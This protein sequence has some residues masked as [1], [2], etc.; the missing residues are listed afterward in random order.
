MSEHHHH[1]EHASLQ[2][3][4]RAFKIAIVLNVLFIVIEVVAGWYAH[5]LS[6]VADAGHNVSDVLGLVLSWWALSLLDRPPKPNFTYG[7]G[8]STNLAALVNALLLLMAVGIMAMEAVDRFQHP[9]SVNEPIMMI[10]ALIG[11]GVNGVS[12][13]LLHADAD[14][15]LNQRGAFL[16]LLADALVSVGVVLAGVG[17]WFTGWT[18]LDPLMTLIIA[19]VIFLT[20]LQLLKQSWRL[21]MQGIP[22]DIDI[23]KVKG[24]LLVQPGVTAL[25]DLHIWAMSTRANALT[26]HLVMPAGHPGDDFL[27]HLAHELDEIFKINHVTIQIELGDGH[28]VCPLLADEVI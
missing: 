26:V 4:T 23:G 13:W 11:V 10:V 7:L 15:D 27:H 1:H 22:N 5:S 6:L 25:H 19:L 20:V 3:V 12:A 16:H 2:Q 21:S 9:V 8:A 24:F 14:Q 18:W 17:I 28:H